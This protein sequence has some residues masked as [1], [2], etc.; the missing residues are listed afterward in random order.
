MTAR[1]SPQPPR[2]SGAR[3]ALTPHREDARRHG[4]AAVPAGREDRVSPLARQHKTVKHWIMTSHRCGTSTGAPRLAAGG[5]RGGSGSRTSGLAP[6]C[7]HCVRSIPVTACIHCTTRCGVAWGWRG[8][9]AQQFPTAA[10]GARLVPVGEEAIMP[11]THEAAGQHM[12][13]EASDT[14]VGVERHGLDTIALTTVAVGKA[15]PPVPHI[16]DPVVRDGDAMRRAA[17][18]VQDVLRAGK[19]RLGVDDPLF[20]IE[21]R[22]SGAK[23]SGVPKAGGPS[24]RGTAPVE[25]ALGQRLTELPAQDRAQGPHREEEAGIGLDPAR[26]VGGERASRDDAVDMAMRP[27]GL[28]PG[29]Q[30]HGAPDLPAEVAVPTLDERLAGGVAQQ[31]QE[32]LLVG[33]DEGVEGVGHGKHQVERGHREHLGF[34]GLDPLHLGKRL[35]LGAVAIA[36]GIRRVP[37]EPTGGTVFGVPT[38]LRGPA[39]FEG[40]HHLLMGGRHGMGTAVCLAVEAEDIGDCP[41]GGAGLAHLAPWRAGGGVRRHG[42]TPAWAGAGPRRAGGRTGCGSSPEAAG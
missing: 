3:E 35:T 39:G 31:G 28:V 25:P 8:G 18:I 21:L 16:E 5:G 19:G 33:Q 38:E 2:R 6:Q 32:G 17:D 22:T 4:R 7:G 14:C 1:E 12:Q 20:G 36:T 9:L 27:Q 24:A 30:D 15:D 23:L 42:V 11:E 34:A 40:A 41:R 26:P 10:Q 13:Q 37:F 29:V